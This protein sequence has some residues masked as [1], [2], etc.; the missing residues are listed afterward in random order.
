MRC[1]GNYKLSTSNVCLGGSEDLKPSCFLRET[2][3]I[4]TSD[5]DMIYHS[6]LNKKFRYK[7]KILD[8]L[9]LRFR[10]EYLSQLILKNKRSEMRKIN[11][12]A[13]VL[14]G[15]DIH[16]R[17]D[18][19]LAR[20]IAAIPGKDGN[21]R[22]FMLKT[23]NGILKRAIQRLYPLE[24]SH[25]DAELA[26]SLSEIAKTRKHA[27]DSIVI[28]TNYRDKRDTLILNTENGNVDNIT[29][30]SGRVIQKPKRFS[31]II[32]VF[33]IICNQ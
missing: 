10:N 21:A 1:G 17:I 25:E 12:G 11:V 32:L 27:N 16:K 19:P 31:K 5:C 26:Q 22:V 15:D 28:A 9:R 8:A 30:R 20:V 29:T 6:K 2:Q 33:L 4:G 24:I 23:K 13:V 7:Q 3:E 14:I 18:W